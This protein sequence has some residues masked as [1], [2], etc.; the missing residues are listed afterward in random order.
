MNTA[1]QVMDLRVWYTHSQ[2]LDSIHIRAVPGEAVILTGNCAAEHLAQLASS[3]VPDQAGYYNHLTCEENL[4]MPAGDHS[5]GGALSLSRIYGLCPDLHRLR[6]TLAEGLSLAE[7]RMLAIAR[8][9][10][11][12]ANLILLDDIFDGLA[13]A[14]VQALG[15]VI[16]EL[17]TLGYALIMVEREGSPL[18]AFADRVYVVDPQDI[19]QVRIR[20][21][22]PA[23][24]SFL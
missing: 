7:Q 13:P 21:P 15:R 5:L 19:R 2:E 11:T 14:M 9:L 24:D 20:V 17:K 1:L 22:C 23:P 16:R 6:D 10:R 3:L 8:V 18:T 4:L 12:G